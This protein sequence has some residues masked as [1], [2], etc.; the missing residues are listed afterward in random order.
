MTEKTELEAAAAIL[1]C[2]IQR[3]GNSAII[4]RMIAMIDLQI[5]EEKTG[6]FSSKWLLRGMSHGNLNQVKEFLDSFK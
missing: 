3:T 6:T 2:K 5:K 1:I 4:D